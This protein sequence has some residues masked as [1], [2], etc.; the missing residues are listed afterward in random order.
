MNSPKRVWI[1]S[2]S[3]FG[4]E[5]IMKYCS[6]PFKTVGEMNEEMIRR[7]NERVGKKDLVFHLGDFAMG[8]KKRVEEYAQRLNGQKSIVLGNHDDWPTR[9]WME[10]GFVWASRFPI[11]YQDFIILSHA[12]QFL[13]P[14]STF[15]NVHGHVH[16]ALPHRPNRQYMNVSV[17][18][19]DFYP[20]SLEYVLGEIKKEGGTPSK[21]ERK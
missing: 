10:H 3:H 15:F 13:D 19:T 2:D 6:R 14:N 12:Q 17:D 8:S 4:H 21:E 11:I 7:W 16:V 9:W 20:V 1:T 5:N 18:V